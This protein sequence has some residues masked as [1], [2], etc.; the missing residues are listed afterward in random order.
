MEPVYRKG[1]SREV[2][3]GSV[4]LPIDPENRNPF[5]QKQKEKSL[6]K[7]MKT[8]ELG[9]LLALEYPTRQDMRTIIDLQQKIIVAKST[10]KQTECPY[11]KVSDMVHVGD[12]L[13]FA[14][15]TCNGRPPEEV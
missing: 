12:K 5:A 9:R 11:Y 6:E 4:N 13:G 15:C 10:T 1:G 7:Q 2:T 8:T 3:E 14:K